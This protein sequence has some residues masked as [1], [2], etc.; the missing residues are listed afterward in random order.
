MRT[1]LLALFFVLTSAAFGQPMLRVTTNGVL[2]WPGDF[3]ATNKASLEAALSNGFS[4]VFFQSG[5]M[6]VG[7][8]N[9]TNPLA[10]AKGGTGASNALDARVA[11]GT[12]DAGNITAGT[13]L[14]ARI[15]AAIARLA[16][17]IFS[18][19]PTAP[20]PADGDDDSSIPTTEWVNATI[21]DAVSGLG[22]GGG[23]DIT[24]SGV[25]SNATD[26]TLLT[27]GIPAGKAYAFDLLVVGAG[28]TNS[29]TARLVASAFNRT[30]GGASIRTNPPTLRDATGSA[31]AWLSMS[32]TSVILNARGPA[33]EKFNWSLKGTTVALDH[34]ATNPA[35]GAPLFGLSK[36]NQ[37][38]AYD[39][40]DASDSHSGGHN[41]SESNSPSYSGGIGHTSLATTSFWKTTT[42][43][44]FYNTN[45]AS[46]FTLAGR[47]RVNAGA[48]NGRYIFASHQYRDTL[49]YNSPSNS[50]RVAQ[51][52]T[53]TLLNAPATN[54]W[55]NFVMTYNGTTNRS[56]WLNG[57]E[58]AAS[59]A[60]AQNVGSLIIGTDS[61]TGAYNIPI[62]FDWFYGWGRVLTTNEIAVINSATNDNAITY[63]L[64]DP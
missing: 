56:I 64:L 60:Y 61:A 38:F 53:T 10:V 16:S 13:L 34:G 59:E 54:E 11:L 58:Y 39:F 14:A 45:S 12:H 22:G 48:S 24:G 20:T 18:G 17:P 29:V 47:V 33:N 28:P 41:L 3:F 21:A 50:A 4:V 30:P 2:A 36:S 44:L 27:N 35:G 63:G 52:L 1:T 62:S 51:N 32:G 37:L 25:S 9:L 57:I 26:F 7:T 42:A 8:L 5:T 49:R 15:D 55:L 40:S 19:D 31:D 43:N 6:N 46:S 23:F